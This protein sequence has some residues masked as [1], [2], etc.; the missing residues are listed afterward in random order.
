MLPSR[1]SSLLHRPRRLRSC[2]PKR[3][4]IPQSATTHCRQGGKPLRGGR[5]SSGSMSIHDSIVKPHAVRGDRSPHS[6]QHRRSSRRGTAFSGFGPNVQLRHVPP[7]GI[8][9]PVSRSTATCTSDPDADSGGAAGPRR[10]SRTTPRQT[11]RIR[12]PPGLGSAARRRDARRSSEGPPCPPT[13]ATLG[14]PPVSCPSPWTFT[15]R[16]RSRR[17]QAGSAT[18]ATGSY[19]ALA[20]TSVGQPAVYPLTSLSSRYASQLRFSPASRPVA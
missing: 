14:A 20:T 12:H 7:V 17:G 4:A 9:R 10:G 6:W 13:S 1:P 11:H 16:G 15:V 2:W 8:E 18:F 3:I 19:A 5:P